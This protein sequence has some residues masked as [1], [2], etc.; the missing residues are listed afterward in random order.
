M[1]T[2][3]PIHATIRDLP[4]DIVQVICDRTDPCGALSL[5][6][7]LWRGDPAFQHKMEGDIMRHFQRHRDA[8]GESPALDACPLA[9]SAEALA[10]HCAYLR[11]L[12]PAAASVLYTRM[13]DNSHGP[14]YLKTLAERTS[15]L[16]ARD[17]ARCPMRAIAAY[18]YLAHMRWSM[19][20]QGKGL[21]LVSLHAFPLPRIADPVYNA[22]HPPADT[23][24]E[25][26]VFL[27]ALAVAWAAKDR[28]KT[29]SREWRERFA[30]V[31]ARHTEETLLLACNLVDYPDE[32]VA[33][34][35]RTAR[36][37]FVPRKI[38]PLWLVREY[39]HCILHAKRIWPDG[40]E[41]GLLLAPDDIYHNE[42]TCRKWL[43]LDGCGPLRGIERIRR[44]GKNSA[45]VFNHLVQQKSYIVTSWRPPL[46]CYPRT[47]ALR[48]F[49]VSLGGSCCP[50]HSRQEVLDLVGWEAVL[51]AF[52]CD[53]GEIDYDTWHAVLRHFCVNR[54]ITIDR[55]RGRMLADIS[56]I[57]RFAG[58]VADFAATCAANPNAPRLAFAELLTLVGDQYVP[59]DGMMWINV[60][61]TH[62]VSPMR[63]LAQMDSYADNMFLRLL[64]HLQ[65]L[66]HPVAWRT[67][68][69]AVILD[70]NR[71][72]TESSRVRAARSALARNAIARDCPCTAFVVVTY[73]TAQLRT[74]RC[75]YQDNTPRINREVYVHYGLEYP[76][77]YRQ[78]I[79]L[80]TSHMSAA[81]RVAAARPE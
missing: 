42:D 44:L 59:D 30:A 78:H 71:N 6:A 61:A 21:D 51:D 31:R 38:R 81:K 17:I 43:P 64:H 56:V 73:T 10:S 75:I 60:A 70:Y 27:V 40:I 62:I 57:F 20:T 33:W 32:F 22:A 16:A 79:K 13:M 7:V 28:D 35:K 50:Q 14:L 49:P 77:F 41:A 18:T 15:A 36:R 63:P 26:Y 54:G 47:Y 25:D 55:D 3:R 72:S 1:E 29:D 5:L 34:C 80:Q 65:Q 2:P 74:L 11:S 53:A 23:P 4:D 19:Y 66:N 68:L 24:E 46:E 39:V 45:A 58:H 52:L 12:V 67:L 37:V 76:A 9:Y 48:P 8:C 69:D